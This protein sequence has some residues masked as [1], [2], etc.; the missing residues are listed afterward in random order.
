MKCPEGAGRPRIFAALVAALISIAFAT[1]ARASLRV[2]NNTHMLVNFAIGYTAGDHFA[3]EGWWTM[4]PGSC[5]TPWRE[6]LP[7]RFVYIYAT[8][9]DGVDVL[10]GKVSMCVDRGQVQ[11]LRHQRL[12]AARL[13][14]GQLRRDRQRRLGRL[15]DVPQRRAQ[16]RVSCR[17]SSSSRS[18]EGNTSPSRL[19]KSRVASVRARSS[20]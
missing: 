10:A 14:G 3:T 1:P 5:S 16:V 17:S 6:A 11:D 4:T 19:R 8:D 13:A 9:I 20:R 7:G 15:D 18:S 12:L 2:C